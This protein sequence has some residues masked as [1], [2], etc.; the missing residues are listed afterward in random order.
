[1]IHHTKVQECD[2]NEVKGYTK[3]GHKKIPIASATEINVFL[4]PASTLYFSLCTL[5]LQMGLPGFDSIDL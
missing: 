1:M 5:Y 2:A 3:V 4:L